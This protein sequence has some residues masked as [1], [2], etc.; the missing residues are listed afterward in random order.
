MAKIRSQSAMSMV[1]TS[2]SPIIAA[3]E[4]S[5][6][7][8]SS[9]STPP[10]ADT[11]CSTIV[12]S[13]GSSSRSISMASDRPPSSS[14][15]LDVRSAPFLLTSATTTVAPSDA[16]R[17]HVTA[18]IPVA[19][20]TTIATLSSNRRMRSPSAAPGTGCATHI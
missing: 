18:P 8:L 2:R 7:L 9:R 10:K 1:T 17:R 20:P 14:I 4:V 16:R 3:G 11:V 19:P 12:A 6:A 5:A 15:V 13:D